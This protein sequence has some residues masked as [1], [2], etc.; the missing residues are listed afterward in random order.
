MIEMSVDKETVLLS[1]QPAC[2]SLPRQQPELSGNGA[3]NPQRFAKT[4]GLTDQDGACNLAEENGGKITVGDDVITTS[5]SVGQNQDDLQNPKPHHQRPSKRR[6]TISGGFKHP[7]FGKRRRRANSESESVLPTNFLLGG[8]I[9]DPLNLNSLLDEEVNRALNAET[10]KSSPLPSKSRDPVEI[11]IP[12]DITDPLNLNGCTRGD[13]GIVLTP[14]KSGGGRRRHRNRHHGGI[15][16][17]GGM[18]RGRDCAVGGTG[19][20]DGVEA[21][22]EG[23]TMELN[24]SE[25]CLVPESECTLASS[26]INLQNSPASVVI[27]KEVKETNLPSKQEEHEEKDRAQTPVKHTSHRQHK[28]KRSSSRSENAGGPCW[29]KN[30]TTGLESAQPHPSGRGQQRNS[31]KPYSRNSNQQKPNQPHQ[32]QQ[33]HKKKFQYGNYN[34]YYGYRNPGAI[35]DIRIR[36]FKQEW[37]QGK[38]VLDIGCNVGHMTLTIAKHWRPTRILGLDIDS[39][40]IHAAKQN[41]RHYLSE[42]HALQARKERTEDETPNTNAEKTEKKREDGEEKEK[43][44]ESENVRE[45]DGSED[46]ENETRLRESVSSNGNNLFP[47]SLCISRGPIAAPPLPDTPTPP[48]GNFPSNVT[49]LRVRSPSYTDPSD[50]ACLLTGSRLYKAVKDDGRMRGRVQICICVFPAQC[51]LIG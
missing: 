45:Q 25:G 2:A 11:L 20:V 36:V 16:A 34:Q 33:K 28:R 14:F 1:D 9:F 50:K 30:Q 15:A 31:Y 38:E 40:L 39:T 24:Q 44:T 22:G 43:E 26:G 4:T 48:P 8:N 12:R 3:E 10:P 7:V 46:G 21:A 27:I 51:I 13:A 17:R 37:F 19:G 42:V 5:D 23:L 49:F 35:E 32:H 18:L 47:A 29:D 6:S 41:I